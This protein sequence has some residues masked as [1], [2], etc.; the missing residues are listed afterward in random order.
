MR[1]IH[2]TRLV[3]ATLFPLVPAGAGGPCGPD[4]PFNLSLL[5]PRATEEV[6]GN[7]LDVFLPPGEPFHLEVTVNLENRADNDLTVYACRALF[8]VSVR[9]D[10]T[11][12]L[13]DTVSFDGTDYLTGPT[14]FGIAHPADPESGAGF[15]AADALCFG[16]SSPILLTDRISLV[17]ARYSL[18]A[19]HG[20][21]EIGETIMTHLRF[22]D[23]LR[24]VNGGPP[25]PNSA[26]FEGVAIV[27]CL[28]NLEV[29]FHIRPARRFTR[30]DANLDG[31]LNISDP[32]AI[33]KALFLPTPLPL[34]C[35][36]AADGND[37][38]SVDL[39]DAIGLL[40][41]LFLGEL[42]PRPPFPGPGE[43]PTADELY[44]VEP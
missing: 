4:T 2:A 25:V 15:V 17:R 39:D 12:L 34:H 44:C 14:V 32:V 7:R 16:D 8:S 5:A 22:E 1:G 23:G 42:A 43:D 26:T 13:L 31:Q 11:V 29:R 41:Y 38:G 27:P 24:T 33:L 36:D 21:A 19:A 20:P 10:G 3:L 9:H 30:G 40:G 18:V 28:R 6:D 37:D 35:G